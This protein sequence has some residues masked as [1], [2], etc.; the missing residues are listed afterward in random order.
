MNTGYHVHMCIELNYIYINLVS[1]LMVT[2]LNGIITPPFS[3]NDKLAGKQR[4]MLTDRRVEPPTVTG[5]LKYCATML[6]LK[7]SITDFSEL[8]TPMHIY[9]TVWIRCHCTLSHKSSI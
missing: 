1:R 4:R 6:R 3:T 2:E 8:S 9:Y 7:I 5:L